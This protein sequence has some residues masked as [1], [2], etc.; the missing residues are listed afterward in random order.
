MNKLSKKHCGIL[1]LFTN[2]IIVL[3]DILILCKVLPFNLVMGGKLQSYEQAIR[4]VTPSIVILGLLGV[5]TAISAN[6]IVCN[7]FKKISNGVLAVFTVYF[8]LNFILNLLGETWFENIV[9]NLLIIIQISCFT[10]IL[11][12]NKREQKKQSKE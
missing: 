7:K 3:V 11:K 5:C 8:C 4:M 1:A 12:A 9:A 10:Y 6:I 2:G